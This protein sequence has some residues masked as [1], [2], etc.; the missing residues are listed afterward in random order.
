L[1]EY[2]GARYGERVKVQDAA[3]LCAMSNS[4][5]MDFF[6]RVTGQ[7][8]LAYL[9]H[10]RIAKAESLLVSTEKSIADIS[11]EI[12]FCDQGHFAKAFRKSVGMTPLD[13]RHQFGNS[14]HP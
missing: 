7:S 3:R 8:F 6:K 9:N 11:Q 13:Y 10:F 1:F 2:L 4:Y 12:S 5:F 14:T